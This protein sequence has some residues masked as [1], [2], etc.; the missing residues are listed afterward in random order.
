MKMNRQIA[1]LYAI[2]AK[3]TRTIIGLMSGTSLDGL[4][5]AVCRVTGSG[6]DTG[7]E[8]LH[9][10]TMPYDTEFRELILR[11]FAKTEIHHPDIC[12][13]NALIADRH[14]SLVNEALAGWG[15]GAEQVDLIASHGQTVF[16]APVTSENVSGPYPNSTLQIGDGDHIAVKTGII[17]IS[18][19]RQKHVAAG[20]EGAPLALYGDF[21]LFSDT[22]EDR[23]LLNMG[24]IAN[25]TYL[26]SRRSYQE[27]HQVFATDV[28]P[29][30][31]LMNQYVQRHFGVEM[32]RDATLA[33]QGQVHDGLLMALMDHPFFAQSFP[34]TT[35]PEL[36]NLAYLQNSQEKSDTAGLEKHDVMAT[37]CAFSARTI[38]NAILKLTS[39][40]PGSGRAG[41]YASGGGLSNPLLMAYIR[42]ELG[43]RDLP[44]QS[45]GALG[46]EPDAKEAVLFAILANET[47]AGNPEHV[48]A[49]EGAPAICMGKICLPA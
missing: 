9:F 3:S 40:L 21:L 45:F 29:A 10:R 31:T 22:D 28:G 6:R 23:I 39:N 42:R 47:L 36:F 8:V 27:G 4:D 41:V 17:T 16:H 48:K 1:K 38:V 35:G 44:V 49:V 46:I 20:G 24:G 37:L 7:L 30:N 15:I 32:D 5:I 13:L 11:V 14:A 33:S 19:F 43:E 2:A 26:P 18:D 25:F 12:G 34:K